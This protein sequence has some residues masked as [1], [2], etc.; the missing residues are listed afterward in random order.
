MPIDQNFQNKGM[1]PEKHRKKD[2]K[3]TVSSMLQLIFLLFVPSKRTIRN[4][5]F[6]MLESVP[7]YV[8]S[9]DS[10]QAK[11]TFKFLSSDR[12]ANSHCFI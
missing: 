5:L 2:S 1:L 4:W 9:S 3:F 7:R 6:L 8:Q 12:T 10:F 11:F